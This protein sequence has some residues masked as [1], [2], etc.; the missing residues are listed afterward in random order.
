MSY[1]AVLTDKKD[2][3][4]LPITTAENVFYSG[5][6]TVKQAI[7]D[8]IAGNFPSEGLNGSVTKRSN[9][10]VITNN[11]ATNITSTHITD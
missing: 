2:E 1:N 9:N 8:I 11:I 10:S 6:K 4:V 3:Q 5:N 7:D